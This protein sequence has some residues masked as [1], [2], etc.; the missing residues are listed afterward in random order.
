MG[1]IIGIMSLKGGVGKTSVVAA[2]GTAIAQFGKKVLLIDANFS[3]PNLGI[4][5]NLIDAPVTLH[6]VLTRKANLND[7]IYAVGEL[8]II[9]ASIFNDDVIGP[10]RLRENI[11]SLK[12]RYD[13]ILIDSSPSLG[14]EGL[15][16]LFASDEVFFVINPDHSSL[17]N[18]LKTINR[19]NQRKTI[20]NGLILNKVHDRDFELTLE[21]IESTTNIPVMAVI[22]YEIDVLEAQSKF[23]PSVQ[24]KPKSKG[25]KEYK[26]LAASLIGEEYK[27]FDWRKILGLAPKK[28]EVNRE[29]FY[30]RLFK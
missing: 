3:A 21:Q 24:F 2:L 25:S 4:H 15:A 29:L 12:K 23:I 27:T 10:L 20:I 7:A 17:S 14:D 1:K 9:P 26:K 30:E 6:D 28:E 11:K 19:A 16:T 13:V 18:T 5:F 22:P 8:D